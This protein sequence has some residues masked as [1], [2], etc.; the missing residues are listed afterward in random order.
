MK[1]S[2]VPKAA[3]S[4]T[5]NKSKNASKTMTRKLKSSK[6]SS[7]KKS[8]DDSASIGGTGSLVNGN[9]TMQTL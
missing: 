2:P 8:S 9:F 3:K 5:S 6:I 4:L 1:P 7:F